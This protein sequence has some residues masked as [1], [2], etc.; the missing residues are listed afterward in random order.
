M[1]LLTL[2]GT[3]ELAYG[4]QK[5]EVASPTK[6]RE[7]RECIPARVP[8]NVELDLI[9]A[10]KLPA[11]LAKGNQIYEL[12]SLEEY[13]WWYHRTFVVP[14]HTGERVELVLEGLDCLG[15]VW[16]NGHLLGRPDNMFLSHRFDV[17]DYLMEE[18]NELTV[19]IESSVLAGKEREMM[20]D[21][22][23]FSYNSE[24]LA[25][26]KAPHM[27]GWDIMPRVVS[28]GLWRSVRLE[29][30]PDT[31]ITETYWRTLSIDV[32]KRTARVSVDWRLETNLDPLNALCARV[33]LARNGTTSTE[34]DVEITAYSGAV[35][36]ELN[37]VEF[38]W[39][40]G[41]GVPALYVASVELVDANHNVIAEKN[42]RLGIRTIELIRTDITSEESPGEF[43]FVING[44]K[45]FIKGTNWVP[46]DAFHSQDSQH[47]HRT[48]DMVLDL[49]CNMLRCWGG[50]VYEDRAFY[51]LCDEHGVMVWQDF[52]LACALYPQTD[53]F[54]DS[55]RREAEQ[56]VRKF[57]NHASLALWAGDNECD[58]VYGWA[59]REQIDPNTNRLTREVL[60][61]VLERLDPHRAYLPSSPYVSPSLF[62]LPSDQRHTHM[63]ED[64]LWGPRDDFK[65][66]F[67]TSSKVHFVSEIGYHGCPDVETLRKMF[68]KDHLW[69]WQDNDQWLTH[70]VRPILE[71]TDY[72]YR[73]KLMADQ[74]AVLFNIIPENIEDFVLASQ[75]SQAEAMKFFIEK[76]RMGKWR[77]TGLLWWNL[78]DGWPILSDAVVDYYYR[79]KLAY[80]FMKR[81]QTNVCAMCREAEAGQHALVIANDTLCPADGSVIVRDVD[82]QN[83]LL[84][85]EYRVFANDN[86]IV[87][88][89]PT[90]SAPSMWLIE[91]IHSGQTHYNHYL[92]GSRPFSFN[93]YKSWLTRIIDV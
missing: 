85:S 68:D 88:N 59:G 28:A 17:T 24:S 10:G 75:I 66:P 80:D 11:D 30:V 32:E 92:A 67:Y 33:R 57:R 26:R 7:G 18:E 70:A 73:I 83:T 55:I 78:R 64:H 62:A 49:N 46:L 12:L 8:G 91:Y 6:W 13:E 34:T 15:T 45:V 25:I 72:N 23:S 71:S 36:L 14:P 47:L 76:F 58:L 48:F 93:V 1:L 77:Q 53:D 4:P 82:T 50:N 29:T 21:E 60:P 31:R 86:T 42:E 22:W 54:A 87:G 69:P 2:D 90:P 81:I 52:A 89:I 43:V 51:E 37:D 35:T 44:K 27:F 19:R 56:V 40:R 65:G 5:D 39:S 3:W 16:L 84:Q 38:W 41:M 61:R 74:I 79:K 63:P 20:P 9:A